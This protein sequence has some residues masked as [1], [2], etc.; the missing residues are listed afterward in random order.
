MLSNNAAQI[1]L[2]IS[3]LGSTLTIIY[4]LIAGD[5]Y[6]YNANKIDKTAGILTWFTAV[7]F[8]LTFGY[9]LLSLAVNS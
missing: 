6:S 5:M 1:L 7:A 2:G 9:S 8:V 3:L 4:L